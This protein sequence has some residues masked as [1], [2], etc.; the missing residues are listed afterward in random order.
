MNVLV[1]VTS[2]QVY[3]SAYAYHKDFNERVESVS[4]KC[5]MY[6]ANEMSAENYIHCDGTQLRL[7]DSDFGNEQ[8]T[9]SDHYVWPT[10]TLTGRLLCIFSSRVTFSTITLHYFRHSD[11]G[12]P[13]M[14]F[15]TVSDDLYISGMHQVQETN[16]QKLLNK[17][18]SQQIKGV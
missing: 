17:V 3:P 10:G 4:A 13:R 6:P 11:R 14:R 9:V 5:K 16:T 8:Y 15:F 18:E 7:T 1:F 12:L 2:C